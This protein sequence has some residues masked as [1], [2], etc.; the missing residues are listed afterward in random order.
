M[1]RV[2]AVGPLQERRNFVHF[3]RQTAGSAVMR[4]YANH[5]DEEGAERSFQI[6]FYAGEQCVEVT[7]VHD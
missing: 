2:S 1:R 3:A 6:M 7:E 5:T 4:F